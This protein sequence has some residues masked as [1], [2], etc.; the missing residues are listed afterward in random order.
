MTK[1]WLPNYWDEEKQQCKYLTED[2]KC[3][4]YKYR[5]RVCRTD[6][7]KVI[8]RFEEFLTVWC[9]FLSDAI[10]KKESH[11]E[12]SHVEVTKVSM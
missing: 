3:S 9:K 11:K 1:F 6:H 4:I 8:P 5:P 7:F 2:N 12:E 10:N